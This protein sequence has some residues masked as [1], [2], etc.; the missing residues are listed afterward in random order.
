MALD[1]AT[2]PGRLARSGASRAPAPPPRRPRNPRPASARLDTVPAFPT[3]TPTL[4]RPRPAPVPDPPQVD[5]PRRTWIGWLA[6]ALTA[7][8]VTGGTVAALGVNILSSSSDPDTAAIVATVQHL[9]TVGLPTHEVT[10]TFT[11]DDGSSLPGLANQATYRAVGTDGASVDLTTVR[12]DDIQIIGGVPHLTIPAAQLATPVLDERLSS[13]AGRHEGFLTKNLLN[14]GVSLDEL[15]TQARSELTT[16][17]TT[18][19]I[20]A[21]AEQLAEADVRSALRRAG[22]T[23]VTVTSATGS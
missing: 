14:D 19:G 23:D 3:P 21:A 20:P 12:A 6:G 22:I 7:G 13:V 11:V 15:R 18:Q 2:Q 4:T 9:G 10:T 5:R 17:A 1:A 16:A 8:L